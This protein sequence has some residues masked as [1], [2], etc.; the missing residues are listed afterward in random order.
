MQLDQRR[1]RQRNR[2]SGAVDLREELADGQVRRLQR[3]RCGRLVV[4]RSLGILHVEGEPPTLVVATSHSGEH[5]A[6]TGLLRQAQSL[7]RIGKFGL[8]VPGQISDRLLARQHGQLAAFA[9]RGGKVVHRAQTNPARLHIG[10]AHSDRQ[11][12]VHVCHRWS[13]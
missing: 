13:R 12:Q 3:C 8:A 6:G 4:P 10:I 5:H 11:H 2:L 9:H 1:R 7:L